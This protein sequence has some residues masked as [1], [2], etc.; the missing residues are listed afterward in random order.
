MAEI[1]ETVM[2][3]SFGISW[4]INL[5]KAFKA[6]SVKGTSLIFLFLIDFGYVAGILSKFLNK[7]YMANFGEKWYVLVV[8]II[9]FIMVTLNIAVYFRN[10]KLDREN[11]R[12]R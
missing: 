4:P 9:N 11:G 3:I 6:R 5:I 1:L 12:N 2:L 10:K 7:T 8:Y